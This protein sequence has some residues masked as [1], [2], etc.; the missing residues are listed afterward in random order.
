MISSWLPLLFIGCSETKRTDVGLEISATEL[1]FGEIPIGESLEQ[2]VMLTNTG[3]EDIAVLSASIIEGD[4]N[5]WTVERGEPYEMSKDESVIVTMGYTPVELQRE[6]AVVQIRTTL[7]E[8]AIIYVDMTGKGALSTIDA[9]GDGVTEAEGD[10]NDSNASIYPGAPEICDGLD[11]DCDEVVPNDEAD[12]D[13]DGSRLCDGD[14]D[15]LNP[16]VRPGATEICDYLDNDCDGIIPDELDEDEDGFSMCDNDCDDQEPASWPG[17]PEICDGI[18]NNCS[19]FEDDID[20]D[21]DGYSP[22]T[23]GGDCLDNDPLSY[24]ILVDPNAEFDG[25]GSVEAPFSDVDSAIDELNSQG[26][27]FCRTIALFPSTYNMNMTINDEILYF[28]GV[29]NG[30]GD[31]TISVGVDDEGN[32]LGG[33]VFEVTNNGRLGL[34]NLTITGGSGTGDGGAIRAIGGNVELESVRVSGNNSTGDGGAVSVSSG[35]LRTENCY[36][37][38]NNAGDDGGAVSVFSGFYEDYGSQFVSNSGT[39]GGGLLLDASDGMLYGTR[40]QN[41]SALESGGGIAATS[42]QLIVI[43]GT[44][45]WG[46]VANLYGGGISILN[47]NQPGSY[48][49]QSRFQGNFCGRS[50]GG[51][52]LTGFSAGMMVANNTFTANESN[53]EGA[54][55]YVEPEDAANSFVWSNVFLGNDGPSA[56]F[57]TPGSFTSV[58]YN[59][60]FLT[61]SGNAFDISITEDNGDNIQADPQLLDFSNDG[62][63]SN[64]DLRP[65]P[66]SPIINAGPPDNVPTAPSWYGVWADIDGTRNDRGYTGGPSSQ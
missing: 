51:V 33:R 24:P 19:G 5:I 31:V 34:A 6:E 1:D 14:C 11:N 65:A 30:P 15:D 39:R 28:Q 16:Q 64:D 4:G 57:V 49:R 8:K 66:Q 2:A 18:D 23:T 22:C 10:C 21:N 55:V 43:E 54:A 7:E 32:P 48:I 58:A 52:A 36:F 20:E 56:L 12:S 13:F 50:G 26:N 37:N 53:D 25:D 44:Q 41:N 27:N 60:S 9:D 59:T 62:D 35:E 38:G 42:G 3:D 40:F 63:P 46:N 47:H 45:F 29:G 17:N 61:T